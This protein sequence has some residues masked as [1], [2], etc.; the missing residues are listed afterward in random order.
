MNQLVLVP[1]RASGFNLTNLCHDAMKQNARKSCR[2]Q[3]IA[4][5]LTIIGSVYEYDHP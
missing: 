5:I 2:V 1:S 3:R 4:Q